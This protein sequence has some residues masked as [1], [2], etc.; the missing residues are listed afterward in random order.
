MRPSF[1]EC[2]MAL[3]VPSFRS[4]DLGPEMAMIRLYEIRNAL[5]RLLEHSLY[6]LNTTI[7]GD[8][9]REE[10]LHESITKAL[11]LL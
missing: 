8:N 6:V 3:E 10:A 9:G 5:Q 11:E 7:G 4:E 2:L 1:N